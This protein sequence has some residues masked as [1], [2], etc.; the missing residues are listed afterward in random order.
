MI[1][2]P[3]IIIYYRRTHGQKI[4]HLSVPLS[5]DENRQL[6]DTDENTLYSVRPDISINSKN[7]VEDT[8]Y[9]VHPDVSINQ[10]V[11]TFLTREVMKGWSD[12]PSHRL[13]VHNELQTDSTV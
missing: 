12:P 8:F 7:T 5:S 2:R 1:I 6:T 9:S 13:P 3:S 4:L 11:R 10:I